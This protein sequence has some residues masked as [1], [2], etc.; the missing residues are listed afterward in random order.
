ME[1]SKL[2]AF[3]AA[4]LG[5]I[6]ALYQSYLEKEF[7]TTVNRPRAAGLMLHIWGMRVY[8]YQRRSADRMRPLR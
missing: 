4:K 7:G 3:A 1:G 8:G 6:E 5:E 2:H